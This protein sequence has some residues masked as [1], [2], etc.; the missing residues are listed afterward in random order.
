MNI[1]LCSSI[2]SKKEPQL[3][4]QNK[5]KINCN[6]CG[7]HLINSVLFND[8]TLKNLNIINNVNIVK[9]ILNVSELFNLIQ[10]K[11]TLSISII[12]KSIRSCYLKHFIN[13]KLSKTNII[14]QL[15]KQIIKER[16]YINNEDKIMKIQSIFRM[17]L[18]KYRYIC[19]NDV[20]VLTMNTKM[21][22]ESL[23]FYRFYNNLNN[24]YYAYDIR[25]LNKLIKSNYSSCPYTFRDFR[26][27]EKDKINKYISILENKNISIQIKN[28]LNDDEIIE[29]KCK[30]LFYKINMLDNYTSH[31]WFFDL[32]PLD[33]IKLYISSE[34]IWNYR[35]LLSDSAK[36]KII[37]NNYIF[38]V[39]IHM[40]KKIKNIN[41]LRNILIDTFDI[42]ISN[43]IDINE[44][45][46]GAILVLSALVE[47]SPEAANAMPHLV[48][49]LG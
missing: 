18:K 4:C 10:D 42:M 33:L 40:L 26:D 21:E 29:N 47:I 15:K 7:K 35:S 9:K 49:I 43:G 45:K 46:L 24:K 36:N 5:K 17:Y 41:K 8:T 19:T 11:K 39:S 20:D 48:Q 28:N 31:K 37:G 22:I 16:F 44:K 25:L 32:S 1:N 38:N 30:E 14:E 34:D 27:D 6:F 23:Y 3:Q 12:R 13:T 2:K